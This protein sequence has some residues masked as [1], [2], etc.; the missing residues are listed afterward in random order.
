MNRDWMNHNAGQYWWQAGRWSLL[1]L[2]AFELT[3]R[4]FVIKTPARVYEP[5]W[6][7]VPVDGAYSVQGTEGY[8]ILRYFADGEVQTPYRDG[9]SIVVLGD[10]TTLAAQVNP[11]ENFV[12]L[13]ESAL[14]ERGLMVDLHNLGRSARIVADHV[15]LSSAVRRA[16]SPEIVVVQVSPDSFSLSYDTAAENYFVEQDGELILKHRQPATVESLAA[17]NRVAS[18]GLLD[19]FD[20]RLWF[21][22]DGLEREHPGWFTNPV[23]AELGNANALPPM[24]WDTMNEERLLAFRGQVLAQV[25][26][27]RDAYPDSVIVFLVIPSPPRISPLDSQIAWDSPMDSLLAAMLEKID[28]IHVVYTL[29]IFQKHYEKYQT[30]PRGS[31][32][33]AFN[34]GHLNPDGHRAVAQ[35]L[36]AA[37]K[38]ILR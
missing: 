10:S 17:R 29:S 9:R 38:E 1:V 3:I 25:Q 30:L 32:N 20:F 14:R 5:D 35:A 12:S 6:G 24:S 11:D 8:G 36:T 2:L 33:S 7:V 23:D 22:L 16:F 26:K 34:V 21:V 18:S 15:F 37:L 19:F 27:V 28:S 4:L 13:T 31:F